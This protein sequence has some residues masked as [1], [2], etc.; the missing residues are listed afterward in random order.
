[1]ADRLLFEGIAVISNLFKNDDNRD[2]AAGNKKWPAALQPR[3]N[4]V[5]ILFLLLHLEF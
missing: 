1:M 2:E 4:T 3:G 5:L